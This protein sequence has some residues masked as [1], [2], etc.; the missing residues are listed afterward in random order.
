MN[1]QHNIEHNKCMKE[2]IKIIFVILVVFFGSA[3]S[4]MSFDEDVA[5]GDLFE[6]IYDISQGDKDS[7]IIEWGYTIGMACGIIIFFNN[8]GRNNRDEPT[9]IELKMKEYE[10]EISEYMEEKKQEK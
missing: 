3:F 7:K 6:K 10:D 5:V 4:I 2:K 9:P 8:F 1:I